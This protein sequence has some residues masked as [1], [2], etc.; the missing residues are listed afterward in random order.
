[1]STIIKQ[2]S[3][4]IF[5]SPCRA[6]CYVYCCMWVRSI[7]LLFP[8]MLCTSALALAQ[9]AMGEVA[10]QQGPP[11]LHGHYQKATFP[12]LLSWFSSALLLSVSIWLLKCLSLLR[13]WC[14][15]QLSSGNMGIACQ[16]EVEAH[17]P[18]FEKFPT[19]LKRFP[20]KLHAFLLKKVSNFL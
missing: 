11:L 15:A 5:L 16:K 4:F 3:S 10:T 9:Q 2:N 1:M 18:T 17:S 12:Y 7:A 6:Q 14:G 13:R 8:V 19:S 20:E